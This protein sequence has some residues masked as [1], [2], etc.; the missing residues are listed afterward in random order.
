[1]KKRR[2]PA[3]LLACALLLSL[4]ACGNQAAVDANKATDYAIREAAYPQM[5]PYP[6]ED[7]FFKNDTFDD[8]G[9]SEAYD[10]W[11]ADRQAQREQPEGY[12]GSLDS[13]FPA[14]IRTLLSGA[15]A[16]NRV[17]SPLNVYMAL[18][19]LAELTDGNSRA[20]ILDCLGAADISALRQQATALWNANYC[21]DGQLT[22]ILASS[23]WL[24]QDI[25]FV[26]ET[27]ERLAEV[28]HASSFQGPMGDDAFNK[29]LQ[30]WINQQTGG[31]LEEQAAGLE[32]TPDTA[33]ALATTVYF[34]GHWHNEFSPSATAPGV[35][36]AQ[37]GDLDCDFMHQSDI[38]SLYTGAHFSA[39][40]QGLD[41]SGEMWLILPQEGFSPEALL[42][43]EA[44]YRFLLDG[45]RQ[46]PQSKLYQV[47]LSLPKFD[48]AS[49]LDLMDGLRA[50]GITDVLDASLADFSPATTAT[51]L[52]LSQAEHAARVTIDE[53][54]CTAA[55]YTVMAADA[56]GAL[57]EEQEIDFILDRPFLFAI[58]NQDGLPLFV[59]VV[60]QPT[61]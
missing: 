55:A 9:Y 7:D 48:V 41:G 24:N 32:M 15:G 8:L 12:A 56:T 40:A 31:L 19:M 22:S 26:E 42:Q 35:F 11:W 46:W 23:L 27:M 20:Q 4:C 39:L 53:E 14:S 2:Y 36:H 30:D 3:A 25:P 34:R 47:N 52:V 17:C 1:M 50:L 58:T 33:L 10:S 51:F 59:G 37:D 60:N 5:A 57:M 44:F 28:Y 13:F 29:A 21:D 6:Q 45:G 16:E 61:A 38:R 43:D 49:N 54:G 18:A